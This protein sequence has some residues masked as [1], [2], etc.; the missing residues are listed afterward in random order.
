MTNTLDR[1]ETELARA[2]R[3]RAHPPRCAC[4]TLRLQW[5]VAPIEDAEYA[6]PTTALP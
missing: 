1:I 2:V 5:A 4:V 3:E 6:C